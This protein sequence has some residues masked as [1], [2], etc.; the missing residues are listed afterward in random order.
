MRRWCVLLLFASAASAGIVSRDWTAGKLSMRLDDGAAELE[1]LSPVAFHFSRNWSDA[2]PRL[3]A[4]AYEN[5][6]PELEDA[7]ST[8][9]MRTKYLTVDLDRNDLALRIHSGETPVTSVMLVRSA[10]GAEL[11]IA[12]AQNE[13]VYGL[14]GAGPSLNIRGQ[15]IE[16]QHGYFFTSAGYGILVRSPASCVFDF[17]R[18]AIEATG[19]DS[20]DYIFYYGPTPKE[21]LEQYA[22]L[23]PK[24]EVKAESLDL[25]PPDRLPQAAQKLP[26]TPVR[27]WRDLA[28]L[29]RT[30]LN[31]SLSGVAYPA[32]DL[33]MLDDAP[34]PVRRRAADLSTLLPIVFR[35]AGEGGIHAA[36]R[37][38]WTPYLIT[39]LREAYDR[40][41]PLI[42]PLPMQ[43]P[44]DP[45]S[46]RQTGVFMLGDEVL[47]APVLGPSARRRIELP[48]GNWTDLRTNIEYPGRQT[49]EVNA[50]AGR[51][52]AFI[53]NGWIVPFAAENKMELH[54]FPSLGA[55]FFLWEPELE[56]N[57]QFH[58]A[59]AGDFLRVEIESQRERTYEWILHHVAE[60]RA[61][62]EESGAYER[63]SRRDQLRPGAWWH[64][65]AR[66]NLHLMLHAEAGTD[67]I[68]NISPK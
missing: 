60:P 44:R 27:S 55:E 16:R 13:R 54:Y 52:P 47:L 32:L 50:P 62:S 67:R 66:N 15:R 57:S 35:S 25:L 59:P 56:E 36:E 61:V 22:S 53:R 9:T 40:G 19:A 4:L 11:R 6:A 23:F 63:V 42:R 3:A 38:A 64:D 43:F 49:I 48:R 30:I 8:L 51:V 68:V 31:W 26:A 29:V 2:T 7:G 28:D 65:A 18:G 46:D 20:M 1:W 39:Y 10:A 21:I 58:A 14:M 45:D 37:R 17:G 34:A 5:I 41:Y 12:L 24:S 33:S